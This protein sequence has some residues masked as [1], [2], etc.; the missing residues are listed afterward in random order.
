M[1][2]LKCQLKVLK[3][4]I[5]KYYILLLLTFLFSGLLLGCSVKRTPVPT[6]TIPLPQPVSPKDEEYGHDVL[7]AITR[8]FPLSTNDKD[9][10]RVRNIVSTITEKNNLAREPWHVFVLDA[11]N[12]SN[13]GATRGNFVFVWSGVLTALKNDAELA[14]MLSH[15]ISHVLA[16]HIL[17]SPEEEANQMISGIVGVAARSIISNQ[18][19]MIGQFGEVAEAIITNSIKGFIVNPESQRQE[20]EADEIGMFL[21]ARAGFDPRHN[22]SFWERARSDPRFGSNGFEFLSS[23]PNSTTRFNHLREILPLAMREFKGNSQTSNF[24]HNSKSINVN[25]SKIIYSKIT[26][27]PT[28]IF[29]SPSPHSPVVMELTKPNQ[30]IKIVCR[31]D[32]WLKISEP[33]T[34]FVHR[35][36]TTTFNLKIES[37]S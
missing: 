18:P 17:A 33:K 2:C 36:D 21:M 7:N 1:Y 12:V 5:S 25:K 13:A 27:I 11:D 9:I 26:K 10:L 30:N 37:C 6:G 29:N 3:K 19:G 35:L 16:G 20:L 8:Q 32:N 24:D 4:T 14:G 22:I 15:E 34:G 31:I 23:H 28:P